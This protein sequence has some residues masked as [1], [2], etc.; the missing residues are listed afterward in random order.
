MLVNATIN[1]FRQLTGT[2]GGGEPVFAEAVAFAPGIPCECVMPSAARKA[3]ERAAGLLVSRI[4]LVGESALTGAGVA[5][6]AVGD[7]L[8]IAKTRTPTV[9]EELDIV[10]LRE[11]EDEGQTVW[12]AKFGRREDTESE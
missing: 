1:R 7:R 6:L 3:T 9:E 12:E 2:T 5:A 8:Y 10:E 4:L 11:M